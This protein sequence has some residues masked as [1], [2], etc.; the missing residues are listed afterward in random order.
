M[1][2]ILA[3]DPGTT[4][5]G[6]VEWANGISYCNAAMENGE[7][8]IRLREGAWA[9]SRIVCEWIQ[10]MGMKAGREV[11]ETCRFVGRIEEIAASRGVTVEY[12]QRPTIKTRLCGTPRAKDP[13]VRAA[14]IDRLGPVGTR[15]CPGPLYG[16]SSH[17]WASLAVAIAIDLL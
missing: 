1:T 6:V 14:L 10:F 9:G 16:V 11:F 12:I 8:M 15:K 13:N 3:I 4:H 2:P 17:A 7:L 5:S